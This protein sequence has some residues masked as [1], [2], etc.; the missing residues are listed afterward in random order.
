M[1][2][3]HIGSLQMPLLTICAVA[4]IETVVGLHS[5]GSD[6]YNI[7]AIFGSLNNPTQ[8]S[9]HFFNFTPQVSRPACPQSRFHRRFQSAAS[10]CCKHAKSG[11]LSK[12]KKLQNKSI[13][14]PLKKLSMLADLHRQILSG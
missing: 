1:L 3:S 12:F 13:L 14:A 9:Q 4:Q 7:T 2:A 10:Y 11:C 5:G 6:S 8:F